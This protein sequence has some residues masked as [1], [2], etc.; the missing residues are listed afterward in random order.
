MMVWLITFKETKR[1][2]QQQQDE[3]LIFV[4]NLVKS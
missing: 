3:T 4:S 2:K 1:L